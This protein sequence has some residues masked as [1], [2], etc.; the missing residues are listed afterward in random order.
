MDCVYFHVAI[1][2]Q[3]KAEAARF[4]ERRRSQ[5][6]VDLGSESDDEWDP[7]KA[8]SR[9]DSGW[10]SIKLMRCSS[11][12]IDVADVPEESPVLISRLVS[13]A[14]R[15]ILAL[16]WMLSHFLHRRREAAAKKECYV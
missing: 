14:F 6:L 5:V 13:V 8:T 3:Q 10:E 11:V 15:T 1:T 7:P 4:W 9:R 12:A 16:V 2:G